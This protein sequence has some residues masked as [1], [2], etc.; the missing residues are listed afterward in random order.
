MAWHANSN[1][2]HWDLTG[3]D[4]EQLE[5]SNSHFGKQISSLVFSEDKWKYK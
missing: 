5:L 2:Q 1:G 3:E 4:T